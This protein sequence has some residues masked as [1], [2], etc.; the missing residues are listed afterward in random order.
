MVTTPVFVKIR[1]VKRPADFE[2]RRDPTAEEI[3]EA[4]RDIQSS[5][6]IQERVRRSVAR[7]GWL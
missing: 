2:R 7:R 4:C 5:W 1:I 3:L 6:S